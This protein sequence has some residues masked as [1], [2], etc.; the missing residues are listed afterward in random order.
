MTAQFDLDYKTLARW[1]KP[2]IKIIFGLGCFQN[3]FMTWHHQIALATVK[4]R[5]RS[6][7][8]VGLVF[9]RDVFL[10]LG[11]LV[12]AFF[13]AVFFGAGFFNDT[14]RFSILGLMA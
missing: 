14:F 11:F 2:P 6:G 1:R 3:R 12:V 10:A 8:Y 4:T 7:D 13:A 9:L 5:W